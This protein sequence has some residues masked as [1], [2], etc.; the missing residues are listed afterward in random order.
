MKSSNLP[1]VEIFQP[2]SKIFGINLMCKLRRIKWTQY[3][4][5]S[6]D[7]F[8]SH[9]RID[10]FSLEHALAFD[11]SDNSHPLLELV[12]RTEANVCLNL[13]TFIENV[14]TTI[15]GQVHVALG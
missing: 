13:I 1:N 2:F 9:Y 10:Q 4:I 3:K 8:R 14:E 5:D 11:R 15:E 6:F 12:Y 7:Q